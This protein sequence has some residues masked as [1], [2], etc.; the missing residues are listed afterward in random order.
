MLSP[1]ML[2]VLGKA[3]E[4]TYV[5]LIGCAVH[6]NQII[7]LATSYTNVYLLLEKLVGILLYAQGVIH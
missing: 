4:G 6:Q 7:P 2:I 5:L 1:Y 3:Q